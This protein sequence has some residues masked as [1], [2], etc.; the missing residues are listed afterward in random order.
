MRGSSFASSCFSCKSDSHTWRDLGHHESRGP[1]CESVWPSS[2]SRG[3]GPGIDPSWP[4]R[5]HPSHP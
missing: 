2:Y 4:R 1:V 5:K 3:Q